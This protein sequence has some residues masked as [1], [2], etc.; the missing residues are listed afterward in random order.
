MVTAQGEVREMSGFER[1]RAYA[2]DDG[3]VMVEQG[4]GERDDE[5]VI[6][7]PAQAR[8]LARWLVELADEIEADDGGCK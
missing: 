8:I 2:T 3:R 5:L 4:L 6:L 7:P 1:V